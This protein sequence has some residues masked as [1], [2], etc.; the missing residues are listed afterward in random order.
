MKR[1]PKSQQI[2]VDT[3]TY[4]ESKKGKNKNNKTISYVRTHQIGKNRDLCPKCQKPCRDR[5]YGWLH[6]SVSADWGSTGGKQC[7]TT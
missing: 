6:A 4:V 1:N 3:Q 7:G 5:G 2:Y